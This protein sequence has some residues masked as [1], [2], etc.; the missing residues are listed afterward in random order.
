MHLNA[1][2]RSRALSCRT[3]TVVSSLLCAAGLMFAAA[4]DTKDGDGDDAGDGDETCQG[5]ALCAPDDGWGE[6]E[7][8]ERAIGLDEATALGFTAGDLLSVV[9]GDHEEALT[10]ADAELTGVEGETTVTYS[11]DTQ[12]PASIV[13]IESEPDPSNTQEIDVECEDRIVVTTAATLVTADGLLD[14]RLEVRLTSADGQ[15][16]TWRGSVEPTDI[17]GTFPTTSADEDMELTGLDLDGT[18]DATNGAASGSVNAELQSTGD[19][20]DGIAA[21]GIVGYWGD[22]DGF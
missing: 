11:L 22:Y 5:E 6:C 16:V 7:E 13:F 14:E 12:N 21:Y 3:G 19:G 15:R 10:W 1:L 2:P 4:C 17:G 8:T 18:H 9:A 20:P